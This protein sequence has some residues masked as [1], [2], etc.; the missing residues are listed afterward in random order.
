MLQAAAARASHQLALVLRAVAF[1]SESYSYQGRQCM[2]ERQ[3]HRSGSQRLAGSTLDF[4]PPR[5]DYAF[6]C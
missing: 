5:V 2:Q 6:I 1:S 3:S 4:W